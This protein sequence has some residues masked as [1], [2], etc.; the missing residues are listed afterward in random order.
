MIGFKIAD[1][2]GVVRE[3]DSCCRGLNLNSGPIE[4]IDL[5]LTTLIKTDM[6]LRITLN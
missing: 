3:K 2:A 4:D 1:T 5:G 6:T